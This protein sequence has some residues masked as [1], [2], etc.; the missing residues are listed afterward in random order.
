MKYNLKTLWDVI[1]QITIILA[2][3]KNLSSG[4][5]GILNNCLDNLNCLLS[6]QCGATTKQ[7]K[8]IEN[9]FSDYLENIINKINNSDLSEEKKSEL[10]A[11][12]AL[13]YLEQAYETILSK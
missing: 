4:S 11:Y 12:S 7:L 1:A 5:K 10:R 8:F 9:S 13:A 2:N 3:E 6:Q